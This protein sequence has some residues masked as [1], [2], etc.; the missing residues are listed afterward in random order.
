MT[1]KQ[2]SISFWFCPNLRDFFKF[3]PNTLH[4]IVVYRKQRKF[5]NR[6]GKKGKYY[7]NLDLN[8]VTD[9]EKIWKTVKPLSFNKKTI[10]EILF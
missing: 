3:F 7:N 10:L 5:C 4:L 1:Q 2:I 6:Q 9:N 8:T